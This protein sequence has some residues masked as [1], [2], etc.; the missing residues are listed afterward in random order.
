MPVLQSYNQMLDALARYPLI[1]QV[2]ALSAERGMPLYLVGGTVRDLLIGQ[3]THDLDFAVQGSGL[4]LA[5]HIAD[6]LGGS[7]VPLDRERRTGRV[8]LAHA[9]TTEPSPDSAGAAP[10]PPHLDIASLR[11]DTLR[12]DLEGRDFTLNAIAIARTATGWRIE[13]PLD[14]RQD[15]CQGILRLASPTGFDDDPVRTLRVV[16]LQAQFA[17]TIEPQTRAR[18]RAAVH[19]LERVTAERV[20]D[21][22]FKILQLADA[23]SA[24]DEMAGL[25]LLRQVAPEIAHAEDLRHAQAVVHATERLWAALCAP[26]AP[27]AS[28][29]SLIAESLHALAPHLVRRYTARICD[30]RSYLALLKYAALLHAARI[31]VVALAARWKLSKREA[32]LLHIAIHHYPDVQTLSESTPLTRRA[33]YRFFAQTGEPGIDAAVLWLAHNLATGELGTNSSGERQAANVAQ[34]LNAWFTHHDTRI[35]PTPLLSGKDLMQALDQQAGPQIG[36]LL[37][38]LVEAQAAGEIETRRQ[39]LAYVERWKLQ[40]TD[41][42]GREPH[43]RTRE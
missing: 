9:V 17:C 20:R 38:A 2:F 21:E 35:A 15:L 13:D 32:Q 42:Q 19:L 26:T 12:A 43:A 39:A 24:L 23:T 6:Q 5:R 25:G 31:D 18:L 41:D 30:E 29:E 40:R 7:F 11:G 8:L 37:Q 14:G 10:T 22:W 4:A 3:D 34:L 1:E 16:R 36:E 27:S 28:P 33:I